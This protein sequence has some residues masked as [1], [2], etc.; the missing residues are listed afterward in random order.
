MYL[1]AIV[2]IV[3]TIIGSKYFIAIARRDLITLWCNLHF[4][5]QKAGI[6]SCVSEPACHAYMCVF[7][8]PA[9]NRA[10]IHYA[11]SRQWSNRIRCW[12]DVYVLA[13][14]VTDNFQHRMW[15]Y[16]FIFGITNKNADVKILKNFKIRILKDDFYY[17][18]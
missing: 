15:N 2:I 16:K 8:R 5:Q 4:S 1:L 11:V 12:K 17:M 13:I 6:N 3:E 14:K 10:Y 7:K 18:H 9:I